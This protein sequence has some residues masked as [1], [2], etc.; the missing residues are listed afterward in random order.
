MSGTSTVPKGIDPDR[1]SPARVYDCYLGGTHNFA[2]DRAVAAQAV[3]AFPEL[4]QIMRYNRAFLGRA[5]Q[6]AAR[7]GVDQFLDLGS[8]IPTAGNVH[9]TA[10]AIR[11]GARVVYVDIDPVAVIHSRS[12]L[13]DDPDSAVLQADM[14]EADRVLGDPVVTGMLDLRRPVCLLMVAV[15]HFQPD[16]PELRAALTRYRDALPPG[17]FLVVSH[18]TDEGRPED[19]AKVTDLYNKVSRPLVPRNSEQLRDLLAGWD[20]VEPGVAQGPDWRPDPANPPPADI[21]RYATLVAVGRKPA[22]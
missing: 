9:E 7:E 17:S 1:P 4:P 16:T 15:L 6:M 20:L 3:A 22:G 14:L 10:R 5:V 21:W 12:I 13:A 18:A 2:A 19:V 11:P 8:G